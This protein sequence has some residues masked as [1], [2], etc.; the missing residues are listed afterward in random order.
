M[1]CGLH[2][3]ESPQRYSFLIRNLSVSVIAL[4]TSAMPP[5][6]TVQGILQTQQLHTQHRMTNKVQAQVVVDIQ[7]MCMEGGL[8]VVC[9]HAE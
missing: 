9:V 5:A 2:I 4:A 6:P 8:S 7:A 3:L 1:P